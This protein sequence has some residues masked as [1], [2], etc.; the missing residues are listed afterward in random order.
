MAH[1]TTKQWLQEA[2]SQIQ[3][4]VRVNWDYPRELY[5]SFGA[6]AQL[7]ILCSMGVFQALQN[8]IKLQGVP[9]G[10]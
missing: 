7:Q 9:E 1:D 8:L 2:L 4:A 10:D 3:C 6:L 5:G